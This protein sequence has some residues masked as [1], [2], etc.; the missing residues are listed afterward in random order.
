M[1]EWLHP[2]NAAEQEV[3]HLCNS[4]KPV[5]KLDRK[6]Y[7]TFPWSVVHLVNTKFVYMKH[8]A[9]YG[10]L[11]HT[12][13]VQSSVEQEASLPLH[14]KFALDYATWRFCKVKSGWWQFLVQSDVNL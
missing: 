11:S 1:F 5:I 8:M 3:S 7:T 9:T 4:R 14:L 6:S 12:F 2:E 13:P 10:Q